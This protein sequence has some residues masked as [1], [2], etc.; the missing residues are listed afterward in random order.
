MLL[1]ALG[2]R[3]DA[4]EPGRRRIPPGTVRDEP[5]PRSPPPS[6]PFKSLET[7]FERKLVTGRWRPFIPLPPSP[8][9][10]TRSRRKAGLHLPAENRHRLGSPARPPSSI[11]PCRLVIQAGRNRRGR[12][13]TGQQSTQQISGLVD[14]RQI[15][16][17]PLNGRRLR[18]VGCLNPGIVN[19]HGRTPP[20]A[21]APPT[22]RWATCSPSPGAARRR[23]SSC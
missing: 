16:Y 18:P 10:A 19:L 14:E 21:W 20:V 9:A 1:L 23:I 7:G 4:L 17:L 3:A 15:K 6:S 5:A 11:S 13:V 22:L 8:S 12:C 2:R